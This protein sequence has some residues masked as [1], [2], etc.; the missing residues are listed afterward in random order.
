MSVGIGY[1]IDGQEREDDGFALKRS[2]RE[3]VDAVDG[4]EE[5]VVILFLEF[6]L[7]VGVGKLETNLLVGQSRCEG[8]VQRR[9]RGAIDNVE[10]SQHVHIS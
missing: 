6:A 5:L 2:K 10:F 9:R 1:L 8:E 7:K 4:V 3:F